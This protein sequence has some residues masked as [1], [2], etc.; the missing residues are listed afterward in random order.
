[1]ANC[2]ALAL[3]ALGCGAALSLR[4][5]GPRLQDFF[6]A[7]EHTASVSSF[8]PCSGFAAGA[9]SGG[10]CQSLGSSPHTRPPEAG[11]FLELG[12]NLC[13]ADYTTP[14]K[15]LATLKRLRK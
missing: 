10:N 15:N 9:E 12:G 8:A 2:P 5:L 3:Q 11:G 7:R 4:M 1:M 6:L 13:C 14:S